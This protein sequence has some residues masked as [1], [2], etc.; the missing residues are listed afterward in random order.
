MMDKNTMPGMGYREGTFAEG[1]AKGKA[2]ERARIALCLKKVDDTWGM[3]FL[4]DL[5]E[6]GKVEEAK[7]D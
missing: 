1:Y 3:L 5:F 2:D 7:T 6:N 4:T